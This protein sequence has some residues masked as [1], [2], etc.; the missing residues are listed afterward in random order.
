[1][2]LN[3]G[4]NLSVMV[5]AAGHGKR[6]LPL[7]Q[8]TPKP[9]LPFKGES[10]LAFI[11]SAFKALGFDKI[12]VNAYHL[13][14]Q[15]VVAFENDCMVC[16]HTEEEI[17]ETGGGLCAVLDVHNDYILTINGDIWLSHFD[18]LKRLIASF[19]PDEMDVLLLLC[20]LSKALAYSGKG[21]YNAGASGTIFPILHKGDALNAS[22]I[23]SGV[24]LIKKSFILRNKPHL[25]NFSMRYFFDR[26]QENGTLWG[27]ELTANWCDIGTLEVYQTYRK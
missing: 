4:D 10:C 13:K 15:I 12:H 7:T 3:P 5:F 26:A 25:K 18:D 19:N 2:P 8:S 21:D 11:I 1:M 22:Y 24:Q 16:V 14:D 9:L 17:L 20:P 6:L 27:M 23:F